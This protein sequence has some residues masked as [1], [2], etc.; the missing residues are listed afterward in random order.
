[1]PL[2]TAWE[3]DHSALLTTLGTARV[4]AKPETAPLRPRRGRG[5]VSLAGMPP[6]ETISNESPLPCTMAP[7]KQVHLEPLR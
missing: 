5:T 1:V 7:L 6:A 4:V 2:P 3:E